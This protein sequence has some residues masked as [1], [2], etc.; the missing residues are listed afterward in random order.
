[1]TEVKTK[2]ATLAQWK[3]NKRHTVT[4]N[5]GTVV[6]IE[7]P[8]LPK[9]MQAGQIPNDLLDI[10][11]D[12]ASGRKITKEDIEAQGKFYNH[13]VPLTVISPKI[14]VEDAEELPFEDK[15]LIVEIATRQRDIDAVGHHIGGLEKT[16]AWRNFRGIYTSDEDLENL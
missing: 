8:D 5:S 12:V 4:L 16:K 1:M 11:I 13:L 3:S 15:E 10:A 7:I 2:T 14:T 9:L 6:E